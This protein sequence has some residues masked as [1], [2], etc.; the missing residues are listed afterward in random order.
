[1]QWYRD[2]RFKLSLGGLN[3]IAYRRSL[4]IAQFRSKKAS[5][6]PYLPLWALFYFSLILEIMESNCLTARITVFL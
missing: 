6:P 3:P 2:K 4:R 5:A 1:M